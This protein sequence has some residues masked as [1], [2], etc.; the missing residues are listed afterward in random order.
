MVTTALDPRDVL[1]LEAKARERARRT[2]AG[3]TLHTHDGYRL[4]WHHRLIARRLDDFIAGRIKRLIIS[5]PPRSGKSELV[6]RRMPAAIFGRNP[7]AKIISTS[8]GAKYASKLNRDVQR[9][10]LS[11][12]YKELYPDT[13]LSEK[14][15]ATTTEE[16]WLRNSTEFEIIGHGGHYM[17]AGVGGGIAG[18]G[19]DYIIVDD[20]LR[21]RKDANSLVIRDRIWE[22]FH[23]D[24]ENRLDGD[25]G[26]LV[27]ATRFHEDDLIGRLINHKKV[28]EDGEDLDEEDQDGE[29]WHILNLPARMD[30]PEEK[31]PED[32]RGDGD[33]LWP[34][35]WAGRRDDLTAEQMVAK[36]KRR[37][38]RR[39]KAS[40]YGFSALFQQRPTLKSGD[41][42][43]VDRI[44]MVHS[45][46]SERVMTVRYWD[47]AGTQGG[48]KYTAGVKMSL[49]K[50]GRYLIEDVV[51]GQWS[52]LNRE[53][54]MKDTAKADG[55]S[56]IIWVEKE[57]GSGGKE[58]AENTARN[59]AGY[60]IK[61]ETPNT[62]KEIR[63][64]PFSEQVEAGNVLMIVGPW[65]KPY[66]DELRAFG[67]SAAYKDQVDASS[68][69]FNK[70]GKIYQGIKE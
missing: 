45:A 26:I 56:V 18:Y 61:L 28:T 51:R 57:G 7:K 30:F 14:R 20:P 3:F 65:N 23:D 16:N 54:K 49:L 41:M 15:V 62:S 47:K 70:L 59:L 21:H 37:L 64:E 19:A 13:R 58:S 50:D 6:S 38:A 1:A 2:M 43:P 35:L 33:I 8:H 34:W 31:Y 29:S 22:W 12:A 55:K 11:P 40:P 25:G 68:G 10:M 39:E 4:N 60:R 46:P 27:M 24:L 44:E 17:S 36:S 66:K 48:G 53:N 9:I 52:A 67:P 32:P 63:A 69:A 42:F 5:A